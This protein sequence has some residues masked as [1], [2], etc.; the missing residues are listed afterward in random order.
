MSGIINCQVCTE[1][2]NKSTRSFVQCKC[3]YTCCKSCA[4][5]YLLSCSKNPHCMNC[6]VE[7][8]REFMVINFDKNFSILI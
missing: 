2:I 3:E 6:K 7:W 1:K 8:N 4:K 5:M